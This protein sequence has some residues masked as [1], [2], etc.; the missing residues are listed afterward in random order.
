[1]AFVDPPADGARREFNTHRFRELLLSSDRSGRLAREVR[2]FTTTEFVMLEWGMHY[3]SMQAGCIECSWFESAHFCT[4]FKTFSM[5]RLVHSCIHIW[6]PRIA[7]SKNIA[8]CTFITPN[9]VH[10]QQIAPCCNISPYCIAQVLTIT[11]RSLLAFDI[12]SSF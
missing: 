3:E 11:C 12:P 4:E 2:H 8:V 6:Q 1:M 10:L 9:H 7:L 5:L